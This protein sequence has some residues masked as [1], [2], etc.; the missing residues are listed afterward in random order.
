MEAGRT[1]VSTAVDSITQYSQ[2][3]EAVKAGDSAGAAAVLESIRAYNEYDCVSTLALR[4]WLRGL[5]Q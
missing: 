2:Y 5:S 3:R 1:G 4:D